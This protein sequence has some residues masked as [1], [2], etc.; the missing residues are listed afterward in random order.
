MPGKAILSFPLS[1][2]AT[3]NSKNH[4]FGLILKNTNKA[5]G[6]SQCVL[7]HLTENYSFFK[8]ICY[9]IDIGMDS[10]A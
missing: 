3:L 1:Y 8:I 5:E 2:W 4:P 10:K 9:I 6:P 7:T